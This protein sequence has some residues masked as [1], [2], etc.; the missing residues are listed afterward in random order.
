MIYVRALCL[1]CITF[2]LT[3][4]GRAVVISTGAR[5]EFGM[6]F[7][8]VDEVGERR[9]PLQ[10]SMDELAKKLSMI[11]FAVIGVICLMGII[12][13]R[14]LLE[15]FTIGGALRVHSSF[16]QG[17]ML[18]FFCPQYRLL[19]RLFQKVYPSS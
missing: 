2:S 13:H 8:I 3:G 19:S 18:R 1:T 9:T 14:A 7:S 12:Q 15:M 17:P 6:I 4:Y 5:T 16:V 10:L 11:S